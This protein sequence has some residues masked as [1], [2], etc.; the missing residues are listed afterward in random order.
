MEKLDEKCP[1]CGEPLI[2]RVGRKGKFVGCSAYPK[3]RY[4]RNVVAAPAEGQEGAPAAPARKAPEPT[5]E[6]CPT[7]GKP[8]VARE[9]KR[10]KFIGCTGYPKCRYTRDAAAAEAAP[11][12]GG[13]EAKPGAAPAR[14]PAEP[15]G[16]KCPK[17]GKPLVAREGKRGK[18]LGCSGYPR[19]RYAQDIG[20]EGAAPRPEPTGVKCEKCG[21][22]MAR[23]TWRGRQFLACSAY[24]K[25]RNMKPDKSAPPPPPPKEAGRNCP[26]CGKPLVVRRSRR[27]EFIGCSGY[28]KC[29]YTENVGEQSEPQ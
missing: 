8:L 7:C 11:A 9:G 17:C 18:F 29:R 24:P 1:E 28:P 23:R 3:C 13:G 6:N 12:E 14:P 20:G 27:G 2:V 15:T 4:T 25:C 16:E 21:A 19:C 26:E 22:P 5:G 10:G